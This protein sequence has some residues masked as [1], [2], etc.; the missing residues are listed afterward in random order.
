MLFEQ[1]A[2]WWFK[3]CHGSKHVWGPNNSEG[4]DYAV[5]GGI[6]NFLL[7]YVVKIKM[8]LYAQHIDINFIFEDII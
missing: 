4:P 8:L 3:R 7:Y 5:G 6:C 2:V 1:R